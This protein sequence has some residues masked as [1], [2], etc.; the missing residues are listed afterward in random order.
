MYNHIRKWLIQ[1]YSYILYKKFASTTSPFFLTKYYTVGLAK[2]RET[3]I[4]LCFTIEEKLLKLYNII[5]K[6]FCM[7]LE[8]ILNKNYIITKLIN[9]NRSIFLFY[10]KI[11]SNFLINISLI[12]RTMFKKY[13]LLN[14]T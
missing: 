2:N 13:N 11:Y 10:I 5:I 1:W 7:R 8:Q 9:L 3:G 4:F 14:F 6:L 12:V